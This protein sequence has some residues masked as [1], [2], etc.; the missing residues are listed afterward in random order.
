MRSKK[1]RDFQMNN[2]PSRGGAP[3][4]GEERE[5]VYDSY[6]MRERERQRVIFR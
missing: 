6:N 4:S 3:N 2:E 1:E 5:K